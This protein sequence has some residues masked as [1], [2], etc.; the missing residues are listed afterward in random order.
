MVM[1]AHPDG[2]AL[3][4]LTV[5]FPLHCARQLL[6]DHQAGERPHCHPSAFTRRGPGARARLV[7]RPCLDPSCGEL[8]KAPA[9]RCDEH[10]IKDTRKRTR[11]DRNRPAAWDRLSKQLR[12]ASPL[13]EYLGCGATEPLEVDHIIP[14]SEDSSLALEPLNCRVYCRTHNRAR[15]DRCTDAERQ[16]VHAAIARRA[17]YYAAQQG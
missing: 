9:S 11:K 13:C 4:L 16:A 2:H 10:R 3:H 5:G 17:R 8:I 12:K 6:P 14:V 15:G 7:L 1:A